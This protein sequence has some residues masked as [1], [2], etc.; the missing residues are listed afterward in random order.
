MEF[1]AVILGAGASGTFAALGLE[2]CKVLVLDYGN[3]IEKPVPEY[4][5]LYNTKKKDTDF[6]DSII[7]ENFES[8]D[9]LF[10]DEVTPKVKAPLMNFV[11]KDAENYLN[12]KDSN[13]SPT[14]SLAKGGLANV[15]GAQVYRFDQNDLKS[16]PCTEAELSQYY[17]EVSEEIGISG[18]A[19]DDLAPL[20]GKEP[21]LQPELQSSKMGELILK[22]YGRNKNRFNKKGIFIG[23]PRLAVLSKEH[24]G[25]KPLNYG[26]LEFFLP[27]NS[28]FYS[29]V[30]TLDRLIANQKIHY[31]NGYLALRFEENKEGVTVFAKNMRTGLEE[32][33][34]AKKLLIGLGCIHTAKFV[35]DSKKDFNTRLPFLE[36]PMSFTPLVNPVRI[37][38]AQEKSTYS[39]DLTLFYNGEKSEDTVVAML[40]NLDGLLRSDTTFD[41]PFSAKSNLTAAKYVMPS[42][43][44]MQVYY[45][46]KAAV[47]NYMKLNE[48]GSLK[49]NYKH[50]HNKEVEKLL[51][52]ALSSIG[53]LSHISLSKFSEAGKSIHYAGQL[54]MKIKPEKNYETD[55]NGKLFGHQHTHIIDSATFPF[56]P[57]KNLTFTIMANALK[58]SRYIQNQ[59]LTN[60]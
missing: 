26:N 41:F 54:P 8:L 4:E 29:P 40:Y 6:Y 12:K 2:G 13:F 53:F 51:I 33:F 48:D 31:K 49:F 35:L 17:D 37:G 14:T 46:Q 21:L 36:N 44:A 27:G 34:N 25:R 3:Y 19:T 11:V 18:S 45:S 24:L 28:A 57:A 55:A 32:I 56:L 20:H 52:G 39:S 23:K 9:N 58:I 7:G 1:D 30:F 10:K 22:G 47:S 43:M 59:L 60:I 50:H 42:M 15:W 16:F 5:N 38:K